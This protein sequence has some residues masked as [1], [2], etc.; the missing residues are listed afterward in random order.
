MRP[1]HVAIVGS[2]PSGYFAAASLLKFADAERR[3]R[4]ARRH[5]RDAADAVGP[6]ALRRRARPSEDQVDQRPVREDRR[7]IRASAS[8]ATSSVGEHVQADGTGRALRRRRSTPS[9]RSPTGRWASPARNCRAA[10]PP[11]TSSAGTTRTR[12]SRRWRRT[13][14]PGGPSWSATATSRSTWPASWSATPTCW[15]TPTSP[16][17]RWS[18]CTTAASRRCVV[19]GRRGPLQAHLHHAGAARARRPRGPGDV[20]VI[21]DPADFADI[22]DE[23]L[24]AAGKTVQ[25]KHQGAARLR[26]RRRREGAK[27]RIVFRFRTSP[28]EIKGD[29]KVESIVLGRNELGRRRRAGRRP[30]TPASAR[31]CPPS[32]WSARSATAACRRRAAVR[33]ARR[34]PSRTPTAA[35][36][37][38][39]NEY[40]VGWIKRGPSGVI[41]SNKKD[42][43]GDRRH[44]ARRSRGR[45]AGR[46]STTTI[47]RR[48]S[49]GCCRASRS[50]S[51]TTTGS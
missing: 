1:Y 38:S 5:A 47:P 39:R 6:G 11:S 41:G 45:G 24:E 20:D 49:S 19:I 30:R 27:R 40:V 48:S 28:I 26:R 13:C 44:A 10:S 34:A 22:T 33:R 42:S 9:A 31:S 8:S 50:S 36:T 17:T 25:A 2:G 37:G 29:G 21:V 15:P 23:D 3:R 46:R 7:S 12:T 35:S 51:P 14:R 18:R 32:W 43:P 4:R 16:T